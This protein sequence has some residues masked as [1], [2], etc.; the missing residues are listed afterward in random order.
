MLLYIFSNS[1]SLH[2]G[3]IANDA[4]PARALRRMTSCWMA[5]LAAL[6]VNP[7]GCRLVA[8]PFD[9]AFRQ[10]LNIASVEEWKGLDFHSG[11][12]CMFLLMLAMLALS[13]LIKACRWSI[14]E[15]GLTC[16]AIYSAFNYTRFLFLAVILLTPVLAASL[17]PWLQDVKPGLSP[18][19]AAALAFFSLGLVTGKLRTQVHEPTQNDPRF[20]GK[21]LP[22]LTAFQPQGRVFNEFLWG[23]YLEWNAPRI[24][25]FIDSRVDIF[26]YNGTLKDYLDVV[27]LERPIELLT[28]YKIRY[29]LFEKDSPLIYLLKRTPGWSPLYEDSTTTLLVHDPT[30]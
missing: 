12:G 22:M 5:S 29:V 30:E 3:G 8:Y 28:K 2:V 25:T 10:K 23:G 24:P 18:M 16:L 6:F 13:Q 20:P 21:A 9:L 27:R 11:P 15:A 4:K 14:F 1:I 26:E 7:Y 19:L 17:Q